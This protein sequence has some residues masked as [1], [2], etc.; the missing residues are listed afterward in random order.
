MCCLQK[1]ITNIQSYL[2]GKPEYIRLKHSEG[3]RKIQKKFKPYYTEV[4][5][6]EYEYFEQMP[7]YS[8]VDMKGVVFRYKLIQGKCVKPAFYYIKHQY[9]K[10]KNIIKKKKN[11]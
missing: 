8:E 10:I 4:E 6:D 11:N 3:L 7:D 5:R 1:V 2:L 9:K